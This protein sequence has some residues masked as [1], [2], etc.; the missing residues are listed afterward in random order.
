MYRQGSII[1][2]SM[3]QSKLKQ[4]NPITIICA[5]WHYQYNRRNGIVRW[6]N[7]KL[8]YVDVKPNEML[9]LGA[10]HSS[11]WCNVTTLKQEVN[12]LL[13]ALTIGYWLATETAMTGALAP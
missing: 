13:V 1:V 3:A 7:S 2:A 8:L 5:L 11:T 6:R 12:L 10:L 9:R 4:R